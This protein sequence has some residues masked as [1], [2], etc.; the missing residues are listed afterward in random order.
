MSRPER[1]AAALAARQA[2]IVHLLK[3]GERVRI[4]VQLINVCGYKVVISLRLTDINS[5]TVD[6]L[7][8]NGP[9]AESAIASALGSLNGVVLHLLLLKA[10][11]SFGSLVRDQHDVVTWY[12]NTLI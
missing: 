10:E 9:L 12:V 2:A 8:K 11:E 7:V 5:R 6:L 3:V 4:S 1:E